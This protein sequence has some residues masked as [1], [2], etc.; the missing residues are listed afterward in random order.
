M[1]LITCHPLVRSLSRAARGPFGLL[2]SE[3]GSVPA[4]TIQ[5]VS[6]TAEEDMLALFRVLDPGDGE[7]ARVPLRSRALPQ[8]FWV[9]QSMPHPCRSV[10]ERDCDVYLDRAS[11][12]Q[13]PPGV[14]RVPVTAVPSPGNLPPPR[15]W[16]S[17]DMHQPVPVRVLWDVGQ[18]VCPVI[19]RRP[20][21]KR[22]CVCS[23]CCVWGTR[24]SVLRHLR[25]SRALLRLPAATSTSISGL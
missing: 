7:V 8:T 1:I 11:Q 22:T 12:H 5:H 18:Y 14:S 9:P 13:P 15:Q 20:N 6:N 3:A 21:E 17:R 24:C 23:T 25:T 10:F 19:T 2:H 4:H 16:T